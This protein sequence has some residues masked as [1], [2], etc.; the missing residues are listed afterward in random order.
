MAKQPSPD[1]QFGAETLA[2]PDNVPVS[3]QGIVRDTHRQRW[4]SY[5]P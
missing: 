4:Q 3:M 1:E 2:A 5:C